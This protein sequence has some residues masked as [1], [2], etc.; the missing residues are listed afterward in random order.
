MINVDELDK[1]LDIIEPHLL[2]I[3][4]KHK[5]TGTSIERWRW[6]EPGIM[7]SWIDTERNV[8]KNIH[9]WIKREAPPY[10]LVTEI[11]A[12]RDEDI[13]GG[14][15]R[16]RK[17]AH[18]EIAR[19]SVSSPEEVQDQVPLWISKAYESVSSWDEKDLKETH[20]LASLS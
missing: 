6:D 20:Y 12:W 15:R 17:W 11:N 9:L 18:Y 3:A 4:G 19:E 14:E 16:V 5:L 10:E 7:L 13:D 2:S 8:G 1:I